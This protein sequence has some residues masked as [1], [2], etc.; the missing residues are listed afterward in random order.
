[1]AKWNWSVSGTEMSLGTVERSYDAE[2]VVEAELA[3][4][5][6][7]WLTNGDRAGIESITES[8]PIWDSIDTDYPFTIT[9]SPA[10]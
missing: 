9:I 5:V 4:E 1:M 7:D 10:Q 2:G 6:L 8:S 3:G